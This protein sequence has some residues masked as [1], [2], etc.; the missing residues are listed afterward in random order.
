MFDVDSLLIDS[1]LEPKFLKK[2]RFRDDNENDLLNEYMENDK[3]ENNGQENHKN[4]GRKPK[5]KRML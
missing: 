4:R 3:V 2:K 1:E 5:K